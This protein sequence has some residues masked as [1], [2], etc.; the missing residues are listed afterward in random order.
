M[1]TSNLQG[2]VTVSVH[3]VIPSG[4]GFGVVIGSGANCMIPSRVL[5]AADLSIGDLVRCKLI[6]NPSVEYRYKTPFMVAYVD[7]NETAALRLAINGGAA[8]KDLMQLDLPLEQP[9][10]TALEAA[11]TR[12]VPAAKGQ[13]EQT[14]MMIARMLMSKDPRA[15][16][17]A[18]REEMGTQN[19]MRMY[20]AIARNATRPQMQEETTGLLGNIL[21]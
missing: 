13:T 19:G 14:R 20:D 12:L 5:Y 18:L 9:T 17:A 21:K 16:Q 6:D 8:P 4:A 2:L 1:T 7:P 10:S 3:N 15:L 11:L